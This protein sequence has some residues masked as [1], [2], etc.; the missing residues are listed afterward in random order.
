LS[1]PLEENEET[2]TDGEESEQPAAALPADES[3]E[4]TC[5]EKH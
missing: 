1:Q 5:S 2:A 4:A 3:A